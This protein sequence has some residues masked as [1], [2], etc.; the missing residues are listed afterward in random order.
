MSETYNRNNEIVN[1]VTEEI[2]GRVAQYTQGLITQSELLMCVHSL[3]GADVI[4]AVIYVNAVD[5]EIVEGNYR[6]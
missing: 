1:N 3:F 4:N 6:F 2:M 5:N